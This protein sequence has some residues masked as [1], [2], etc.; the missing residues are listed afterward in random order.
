VA[1]SGSEISLHPFRGGTAS[2]KTRMYTG[3]FSAM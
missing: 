2:T 3:R 1:A